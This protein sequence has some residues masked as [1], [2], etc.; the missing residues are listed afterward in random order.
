MVGIYKIT[1]KITNQCYIGQ[2]ID[3]ARRW[4]AHKLAAKNN[5]VDAPLYKAIKEYGLENFEFEILIECQPK[6]LNQLEK[7][8]ICLYDSYINGYNQTSGGAGSSNCCVKISNESLLE[9]YDL[10]LNTNIPM[11]Q[12]AEAYGVGNDTISEINT[13]KTRLQD[14]YEY[15]LRQKKRLC[16]YCGKQLNR[17]QDKYCSVEC[18]KSFNRQG[19]PTREELKVLIRTLPFTKIGEKFGVSDNAIRK[20]CVAEKLPSKTREI[21]QYSEEQWK[22]V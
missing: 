13:G 18:L 22:M 10:L 7:K 8:Y 15:P 16:A 20:W 19:R 3:I 5:T 21:K 6:E 17:T 4:R 14:G 12:I 11:I 9:I 2:S 1:N